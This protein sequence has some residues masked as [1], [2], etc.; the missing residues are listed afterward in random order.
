MKKVR[1]YLAGT[2]YKEFPDRL[3]KAQFMDL[4][5]DDVYEFFDPDPSNEPENYMIARDKAEIQKAD[6]FVAYIQR[7]SFGTA[8]EIMFAS[9]LHTKPIFVINPNGSVVNDLWVA[10]HAHLICTSVPDCTDHIKT[11]RF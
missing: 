4:L 11:I 3:W 8:M 10:G 9:M 7:P 6:I 1:I 5:T 2:I